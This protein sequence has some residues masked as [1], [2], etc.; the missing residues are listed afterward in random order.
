MNYYSALMMGALIFSVEA[1]AKEA[2]GPRNAESCLEAGMDMITT[3][4][5]KTEALKLIAMA[6][7][8]GSSFACRYV[9]LIYASGDVVKKNNTM[10]VSFEVKACKLMGSEG[11]STLMSMHDDSI[12]TES[13]YIEANKVLADACHGGVSAACRGLVIR[14]KFDGYRST[15]WGMSIRQVMAVHP[16]GKIRR[17]NRTDHYEVP[18]ATC[19]VEGSYIDFVF[20]GGVLS[21]IYDVICQNKDQELSDSVFEASRIC[22][23]NRYGPADVDKPRMSYWRPDADFDVTLGLMD[24][25]GT[26]AVMAVYR[27]NAITR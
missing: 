17:G 16:S 21:I 20:V 1:A 14:H 4:D 19:A 7:D 8:Y 3:T 23:S 27:P 26:R 12:G 11:C 2:C 6:C 10:A 24:V 5:N 22:L 18:A 25:D 13:D 9:G 15:K